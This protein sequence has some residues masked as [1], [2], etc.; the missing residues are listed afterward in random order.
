[1]VGV[2]ENGGGFHRWIHRER[3]KRLPDLGPRLVE[4]EWMRETIAEVRCLL[5]EAPR[6]KVARRF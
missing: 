4:S 3:A 5:S 2:D 1:M 6:S